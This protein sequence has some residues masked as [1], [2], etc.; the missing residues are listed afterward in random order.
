MLR[1]LVPVLFFILVIAC[2]P[3]TTD[4]GAGTG[5]STWGSYF[6]GAG[7]DP[8]SAALRNAEVTCF[9][10]TIDPQHP[11]AVIE[12]RL[13]VLPE[14]DLIHARLTLDPA[15]ADN[16]YGAGSVGWGPD[17]D[18][19]REFSKLVGS[20]HAVIDLYD[21]G[22]ALTSQVKIDYISRDETSVSGHASLGVWDG[23]GDVKEGD[24]S[25]V[26]KASTSLDLNLNQR[27]YDSYT[28][29]SPPTD[30]RF[31][32]SPAAPLWDYRVVYDVW[33]KQSAFAAN[34]FGHPS[35]DWIHASPSKLDGNTLE[36]LS[37]PCPPDWYDCSEDNPEACPNTHGGDGADEG[38]PPVGS[39]EPGCG[40]DNP[41]ACGEIY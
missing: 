3:A 35:I 25:D 21:G 6:S 36:V 16:T 29:D 12:H 32:P 8:S 1:T 34:G 19:Q 26:V 41:E 30:E 17:L 37:G 33:V 13:E 31:T 22:G 9:Y 7:A 11:A 14:G 5:G 40:E 18:D 39:G 23:D 28:V 27:G 10:G 4:Q 15:F 38:P 24:I 20:D 2:G